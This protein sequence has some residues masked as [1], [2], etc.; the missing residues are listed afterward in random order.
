MKQTNA[1]GDRVRYANLIKEERLH[2]FNRVIVH[3]HLMAAGQA[4]N[5]EIREP[6]D[7]LL[8]FVC[9]PTG[10]GK[11]TLKNHALQWAKERAPIL[12]LLARPPFYGSFSWREFLQSGISTLEQP[13]IGRKDII[14][15]DNDEEKTRLVQL[16]ES[17][18]GSRPLKRIRD[19]DLR[20]SLETAIKRSRPAA[21]II[22]DAQYLGRVSGERQ[23]QNQLDCLKSMAETTETLHVL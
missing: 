10:V 9:G 12:S 22:D 5:E 16:D 20:I 4:L 17:W 14:D 19:D 3:P 15:I 1:A 7:A 11:T 18:S 13:L 8:I 21:V 23:L 2:T 6:G